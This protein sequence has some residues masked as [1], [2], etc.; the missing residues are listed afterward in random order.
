MFI[1]LATDIADKQ[2][3]KKDLPDI[4]HRLCS[5]R[6]NWYELGLELGLVYPTLEEI[7]FDNKD[8]G[9]QACPRKMFICC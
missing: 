3:D 1:H 2:L 7:K 8:R 9:C 6:V 5:A 4:L